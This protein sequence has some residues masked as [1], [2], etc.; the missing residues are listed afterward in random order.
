VPEEELIDIAVKSLGLNDVAPFDPQKKIIEYQF[1]EFSDPLVKREVRDFVNE[2]SMDS[3]A[4]GG[5]SVAALCGALGAALAAMVS[6]LTVG[7]KGY[8][9]VQ[10]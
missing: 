7:K 9:S 6:N 10:P 5:G 1:Q 2:V 8:E 3:P 4:P